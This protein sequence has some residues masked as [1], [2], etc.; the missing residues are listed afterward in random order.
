MTNDKWINLFERWWPEWWQHKERTRLRG[1]E[2]RF[3]Y[4]LDLN[5]NVL[6]CLFFSRL[7]N[8]CTH[9]IP[10][11]CSFFSIGVSRRCEDERAMKKT[12]IS[13]SI[14]TSQQSTPQQRESLERAQTELCTDTCCNSVDAPTLRGSQ[15]S[16]IRF[17]P[18]KRIMKGGK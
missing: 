17:S 13:S 15:L 1:G 7:S 16:K 10:I 9:V 6:L 3:F 4:V 5:Y 12:E 2:K 18:M 8:Y 11:L 14:F